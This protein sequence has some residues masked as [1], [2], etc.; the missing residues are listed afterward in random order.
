MLMIFLLL[1]GQMSCDLIH[2]AETHNALLILYL[3]LE[4]VTPTVHIPFF[5]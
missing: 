1:F 5:L 3:A 4:D 2:P